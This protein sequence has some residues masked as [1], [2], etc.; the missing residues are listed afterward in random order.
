MFMDLLPGATRMNIVSMYIL[1]ICLYLYFFTKTSSIIYLMTSSDYNV[2]QNDVAKKSGFIN[3][4]AA[5]FLCITQFVM[6]P[7]MDKVGRR[8]PI[9]C[10]L[11]VAG[12]MINLVTFG[13]EVYPTL[14][15]MIIVLSMAAAP[16]ECAP[17]IN[18]YVQPKSFGVA[19]MYYAF[20]AY[21]GTTLATA[22]TIN[23]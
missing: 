17:L 22:V 9:V 15:I 7:V 12:L 14:L 3:S 4:I 13:H 2:S 20:A 11:L 18:D 23:L 16:T 21:L 19:Q 5:S 1:T 10:G 8:V 6:G